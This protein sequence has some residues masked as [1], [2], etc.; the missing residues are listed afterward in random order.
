MSKRSISL[1][2]TFS[3]GTSLH[4]QTKTTEDYRL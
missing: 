1:N 2:P 3:N 4:L